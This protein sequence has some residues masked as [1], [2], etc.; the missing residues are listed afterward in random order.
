MKTSLF[1]PHRESW[2]TA[3]RI[4][5]AILVGSHVLL[6]SHSL[7]AGPPPDLNSGFNT[8]AEGW[9][10]SD[11]SAA[12]TWEPAGGT[13]NGYLAGTRAGATAA[14]YFVSPVSWS[15]DWSGYRVL[16]FDFAIPSRHYPEA[17]QAG[18][19]VVV[20]ANGQEMSWTASTPLWTWTHYEVSLTPAAF[21]VGSATFASIMAQVRE[22]RILAEYTLGTEI[23]GLDNVLL[24]AAP[25]EAHQTDLVCR[26]TDSTIQGWRPV[27]DVT[28]TAVDMG[29]P[30]FA[31]KAD[32]WMDGRLYKVAMPLSW[33]GD[34]R[35]YR[36]LSFDM[37]WNSG[38]PPPE[39]VELVRIFG[40]NGRWLSWSSTLANGVWTRRVLPLTPETFGVSAADFDAT[41][42]HVSDM[43]IIGEFGEGDDITYLDNIVLTTTPAGPARRTQDLVARFDAG[44]EGWH[45]YDNGE[46]SW[47]ETGGV[48]G[49]G[50]QSV[51]VGAGTARFQSPDE[52][53]GD[54]REFKLLR[55]MLRPQVKERAALD[56][57]VSIVTWDGTGLNLTLPK[58]YGSWTPY[59]VDLTPETFGVA[60]AEFE[61]VLQDVACLWIQSDLVVGT[62]ANDTTLLDNVA[63]LTQTG[64][65]IPPDRW[66]DFEPGEQGWR[67][68]AWETTDEDWSFRSL[69][70]HVAEGGNPGGY[71]E[72]T[73]TGAWT[74]WFSPE[75]WAGDWR[76][77]QSV[78][79]DFKI[80][81]GTRVFGTR[82]V[83]ICSPY[84]SL[85]ADLP[86]PPVPGEWLHYEFTLSPATFG[87][88]I[89]EFD[90]VMR[91]VAFV[92][93]RSEWI[94]GG[95]RE[96]L[97]NFRLSK[98]PDAYWIWISGY[99]TGPDLQDEDLAG[100]LANPD[101]DGADNCHE[102]IAGTD[103]TDGLV[104]LRIDRITVVNGTRRL[105][106][107]TYTGRR[108]SVESAPR[109]TPP[110]GWSAIAEDLPGTGS[111]M[112]V[113]DDETGQR[114]FYRLRARWAE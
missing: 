107:K 2:A 56:P 46:M 73:D 74:Y 114:G 10:A 99:F 65:G 86:T 31:L 64:V 52:W 66:S 21:G 80:I 1:T 49:G 39:T 3:A 51:D 14:W 62:G 109:L 43:W 25:P 72:N 68:G 71:V 22:V 111:V 88:S 40:A 8:G 42:A 6:P 70:T 85:H 105:Q 76:G 92:G 95:E 106:F 94:E 104:H 61:A 87:V 23:V 113:P 69:S 17:G 34:W 108:Y 9:R 101:G 48:S 28:L 112:S 7:R 24:T 19:A 84:A 36:Q 4:L 90:R 32:D 110:I 67:T 37:Q 55:F 16:K 91:D 58:A 79:F 100:K 82:M 83:S 98:A 50:L 33:A 97:D 11:P 13:P 93:V 75:A 63:L 53:M 29:H 102:F 20:G 18:I 41:L 78:S 89:E 77:H 60:P 96:G 47:Q 81:T 35:Q 54:W 27:D 15:G 38:K 12:L 57:E 30:S 45:V 59:T 44:T 103:P 5:G 26:F